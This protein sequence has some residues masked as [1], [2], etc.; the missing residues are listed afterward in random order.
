LR[1]LAKQSRAAAVNDSGLLRRFAPR[2]DAT[3]RHPSPLWGE[4]VERATASEAGEG[5]KPRRRN[6]SPGALALPRELATLSRK[7]RG[8]Y[9]IAAQCA[10]RFA[11]PALAFSRL[12][13]YIPARNPNGFLE[14]WQSG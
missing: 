4:G 13:F 12:M 8:D 14:R 5:Y 2:N 9:R 11:A 10:A 1:A 6:P 3:K 7:G